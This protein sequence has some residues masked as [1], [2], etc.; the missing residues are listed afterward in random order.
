LC[1]TRGDITPWSLQ[2]DRIESPKEQI[3]IEH[4]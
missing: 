1:S 2:T 4:P 3:G